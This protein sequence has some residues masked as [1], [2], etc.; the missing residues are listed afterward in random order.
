M[1]FRAGRKNVKAN[2][3]I[4]KLCCI[5]NMAVFCRYK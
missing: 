1:K 4:A 2:G 5:K 3:M